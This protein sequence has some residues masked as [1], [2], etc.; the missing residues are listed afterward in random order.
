MAAYEDNADVLPE[1]F[2]AISR[3]AVRDEFCR[4]VLDLGGIKQILTILSV[5]LQHQVSYDECLSLL[6]NGFFNWTYT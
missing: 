2:Q 4:Q 3:L 1:I 5:N 6:I